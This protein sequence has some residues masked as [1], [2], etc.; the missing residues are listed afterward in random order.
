MKDFR[1]G[2]KLV[3]TLSD[4]VFY[5]SVDKSKHYMKIYDA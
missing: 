2:N 3:G 5:K 4:G 1:V